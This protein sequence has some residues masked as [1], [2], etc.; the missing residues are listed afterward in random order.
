M[1]LKNL[2]IST[3]I[4]LAASQSTFS[5]QANSSQFKFIDSLLSKD[6]YR[7]E[8]LNIERKPPA[9]RAT[10]SVQVNRNANVIT[11]STS[12][13]SLEFLESFKIDLQNEMVLFKNDTLPFL[14]EVYMPSSVFGEWNGYTWLKT[15][16][17][18]DQNEVIIIDKQTKKST[19]VDVG[20]IK[21][22][23]KILLRINSKELVQGRPKAQF[24]VSCYLN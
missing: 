21:S 2:I 13:K 17:N 4:F 3:I 11:F 12:D 14:D 15:T 16:S 24:T 8:L 6:S 22:T 5:Q 10:G 20:K 7:V 18:T 1:R 9:V 19:Q 23:N